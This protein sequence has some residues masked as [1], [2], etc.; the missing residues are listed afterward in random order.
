MPGWGVRTDSRT[1]LLIDDDE[2]LLD[3]VTLALADEGYHAVTAPN[4]AAALVLIS[5]AR[6]ALILLD[7]RMPIIDGCDFM[8]AYRQTT[9]GHA[10]IILVSA[11]N[12]LAEVA[13]EVGADGYLAKPFE[14]DEFLKVIDQHARSVR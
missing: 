11:V 14:L 6:P 2:D 10:P 8:R 7:V 12:N 1:V 3:V 13:H 9:G 4:G 5:Q